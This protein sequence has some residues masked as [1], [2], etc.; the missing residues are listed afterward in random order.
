MEAA[1]V[2]IVI[3]LALTSVVVFGV[4]QLTRQ[5][6]VMEP[7][8]TPL[9]VPGGNTAS[10]LVREGPEAGRRLPITQPQFTIGRAEDSHLHLAGMLVSRQHAMIVVQDGQY[11]LYDCGSA[12]GT[13][14]NDQR[15]A[16]HRLRPND[17]VRIGPTVLE[18]QAPGAIQIYEPTPEPAPPVPPPLSPAEAEE[19]SRLTQAAPRLRDY[20]LSLI[21]EGGTAEVFRGVGRSDQQTV[22]IKVLKRLDPYS[23]EKFDAEARIL[24]AL[25][26]PYIARAFTSEQVNGLAYI[27]MEYC[28]GGSLRDR[29]QS[30][31]LLPLDQVVKM[32]GQA[33]EGL[34]YAHHYGII[35][36]DI[37]P[38]NIMF[39]GRD[40]V[41]LVDFGIA[42][43]TGST[44]RTEHGVVVGTPLY[45]SYEQAKGVRVDPRSDIYSLGIVLYEMITGAT[46]FQGHPIEV[47][48]KHLYEQPVPPRRV[49]PQVPALVD[50]V[51]MRALRKDRDQRFQ[52]VLEMA[53]ALGYRPVTAEARPDP[54]EEARTRSLYLHILNGPQAGRRIALGAGDLPLGRLEVNPEDVEMSRQHA[55]I[56]TQGDAVWLEDKRSVNGTYLNGRRVFERVLLQVGDE[57]QLGGTRLRLER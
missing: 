26:H 15:V 42:K 44:T 12:N 8:S 32:V 22:A 45:L 46:P 41:K 31:G 48:R 38:E 14:V 20:S 3:V 55:L 21:R 49:K 4:L 25:S 10:L 35:H 39:T 11:I 34:A 56:E 57:L 36:R 54:R 17:L 6:K 29:L 27:I 5:P 52:T 51:V 50:E 1:V 9:P 53:A 30:R 19:V 2:W 47:V 16:E 33:C 40:D 23:R 7:T 37:K 18:F 13:F 28:E 24:Q 43:L